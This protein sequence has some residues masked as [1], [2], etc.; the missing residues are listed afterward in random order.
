M[1][2]TPGQTSSG[3]DFVDELG[4]ITGTVLVDDD[5]DGT[6]DRPLEDVELELLDGEGNVVQTTTTGEDGNYQ[7]SDLYQETIR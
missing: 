2:L 1:T 6:G 3:N 7:F 4:R 5:D